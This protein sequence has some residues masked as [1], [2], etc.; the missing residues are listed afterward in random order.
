MSVLK[1]L[2][3]NIVECKSGIYIHFPVQV[4]AINR[5]HSGM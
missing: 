1:R 5:K 2:I 3:E 4:R